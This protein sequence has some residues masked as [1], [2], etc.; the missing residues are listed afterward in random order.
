MKPAWD[1]LMK[2]F[3]GHPTILIGDSDCT[4]GGKELCGEVGVKGYPTIKFGDPS[5]LEDYKGGRDFDALKKFADGLKPSCSPANIDLCDD[6]KKAEIKKFQDMAP[7]DLDAQIAEKEKLQAEAE[8]TFKSEV[9]KL[10]ATY[11]KLQEAKDA[12]VE[13]VKNSGLGLMKAVKAAAASPK[14]SEL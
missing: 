11:K 14:K 9:E 2:E 6:E 10:Q 7:A 13:D 5:A 4:A 3:E 1:K 8:E 12:A